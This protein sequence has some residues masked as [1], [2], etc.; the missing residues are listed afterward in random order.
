[1]SNTFSIKEA[2]VFGYE[3]CRKHIGKV[4]LVILYAAIFQ[5]AMSIVNSLENP[6][7]GH[8]QTS[9]TLFFICSV[10]TLALVVFY[11]FFS[12]NVYKQG[13]LMIRGG[14]PDVSDL[15]TYPAC[16]LNLIGGSFLLAIILIVGFILFIIPGIFFILMYCF[17]KILII[18]KDLGPIEAF[19]ESA[20]L[21]RG[22]RLKLLLLF[23]I[24]AAFNF[25][26][27]LCFIVGLFVTVPISF[28]AFLYVYDKLDKA[29]KPAEIASINPPLT[30]V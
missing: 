24:I 3:T 18:D 13:L 16:F 21:T 10:I 12:I 15:F 22:N 8:A 4:S 1:M 28:C 19:K 25:V 27:L 26:G 29:H 20:T 6:R 17:V 2:F 23:L 14:D 7:G 5:I 11:I 30:T 9:S